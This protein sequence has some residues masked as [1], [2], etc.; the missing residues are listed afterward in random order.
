MRNHRA[1]LLTNEQRQYLETLINASAK[2]RTLTRARI[3]LLSDRSTGSK[4]T[5]EEVASLVVCSKG[6]VRNVRVSFLDGGLD[7]ALTE[8]PRPGASF[9]PK[10]TA[11]VEARIV[12][13]I[14]GLDTEVEKKWT[15][16][17]MADRLVALELVNSISA[18]AVMNHCMLTIRPKM[19]GEI[20]AQMTKLIILGHPAV[21]KSSLDLF[22]RL[23]AKK[24]VEGPS[25]MAVVG[26]QKQTILD[27]GELPVD[28]SASHRPVASRR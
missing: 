23:G 9:R 7:S 20:E 14:D 5:D 16:Q 4:R 15:Y 25:D 3:L 22:D 27:T 10:I 24:L 18:V 2:G 13:I 19:M 6:T 12:L 21:G 11:A 8:K 26:G 17:R 28:T 1:V